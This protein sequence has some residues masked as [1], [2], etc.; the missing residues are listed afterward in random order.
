MNDEVKG[1]EQ[2]MA[3]IKVLMERR[4][5]AVKLSSN[6]DFRKLILE[7][8]CTVEA[9]RLVHQSCDPA[10]DP[11]MRADALNM[12][13]AGGHLKRYLSMMI[14]MGDSAEK[15]I[16]DLEDHL[17]QARAEEDAQDEDQEGTLQ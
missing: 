11:L 12:A 9:A 5:L 4:D 10:L 8:F 13:Q 3:D 15:S 16:A 7:D 1:L 17:T 6:R 2:Q 14:R